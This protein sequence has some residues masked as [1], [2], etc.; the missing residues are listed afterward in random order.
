[1]ERAKTVREAVAILQETPRTCEYYYVISDRSRDMVG[2][3]AT[4][5]VLE[6]LEAGQQHE[7]LPTVPADT[8]MI[9]APNRAKV[10][11]ERLHEKQGAITPEAMMEIIKRPVAMK[12]NLH[13]AIFKPATLDVWF[14]DAGQKK[15]ACDMPYVH[16]NLGKLIEFYRRNS[17]PKPAP[18]Q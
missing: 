16:V 3:Y 6:I 14:A 11:S 18:A 9:S 8:V 10:L 5:T 15:P 1:M 4:P 13:N 2:I 17:A 12:S 7:R